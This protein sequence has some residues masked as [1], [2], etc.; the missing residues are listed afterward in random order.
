[1]ADER[2]GLTRR[3]LLKTGAVG[4]AGFYLTGGSALASRMR[5]QGVTLTW[6]TWFDHYF[7][8]QLQVTKA[9]TGIGC[10]TKL[11][12][13]DSQIYTTI[14]ATGSQ[15]DIAAADALW[16]PKMHH[17]GLTES[18]DLAEIAASK[19]LYSAARHIKAWTDGSKYMAFPNG[20]STIQVYYNPKFVTTKP[21]SY[22]ALL[23]PKYKGKIV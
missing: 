20:W 3:D 16:V 17:D 23:N 22:D 9:K 18:F 2:R 8:Q 6:L 7:P 14:R 12:P 13:S 1:M 10:R 21:D 5:T 19:Q 4:A 15:F 11:A